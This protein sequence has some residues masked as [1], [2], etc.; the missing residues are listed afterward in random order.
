MRREFAA[1][2]CTVSIMTFATA[3]LVA[4]PGAR[5][6]ATGGVEASPGAE[7]AAPALNR[8]AEDDSTDAGSSV[9]IVVTAQRR[10]ERLVDVPI[11]ITALSGERLEQAG[12]TTPQQLSQVTPGFFY[13]M[14]AVNSQPTVRGV[15]SSNV[16]PG[17]SANVATYIDGVYQPSQFGNIF[18][19]NDIE[20]IEVLKGPQGTLFGRNAT[21]GAVLIH[22]RKP[23]L[24]FSGQL[25][26]RYGSFNAFASKLYVTG[27][28]EA[29]AGSISAIYSR[30]DGYI[31]NIYLDKQVG[32]SQ[33]RAVKAKLLFKPGENTQIL[34]GG[35]YS[36]VIDNRVL[37]PYFVRN[38]SRVAALFPNLPVA[39]RPYTTAIGLIPLAQAKTYDFNLSLQHDFGSVRLK[40]ISSYQRL[41]FRSLTD[42]D[43][44]PADL[45]NSQ[46]SVR[47]RSYAEELTLSSTGSNRLDWTAGL[48]LF[49]DNAGDPAL[50]S[51]GVVLV[52]SF[53][54]TKAIGIF[55]ELDWELADRLNLI[56]GGRYSTEKRTLT[57]QGINPAS[58]VFVNSERWN[59]FTP[60]VSIRYEVTD[61]TNV[62]GTFSK[63]FKSGAFNAS[64]VPPT[65]QTVIPVNP[66]KI[67][68]YEVGAKTAAGRALF[69][70]AAYYYDYKDIQV[71]AF[72]GNTIFTQ[73]QNAA[74]AK[75]WG[76]EG[77]ASFEPLNDLRINAGASYVHARY[78][79]FP[80][81][82]VLVPAAAGGNTQVRRDVSH[83]RMIR[84]PDYTLNL[85]ATYSTDTNLGL[86]ELSVNSQFSGKFFWDVGNTLKE[87]PYNVTN[88]RLSLITQGDRFRISVFADNIFDK[89][90]NMLAILNGFGTRLVAARP[91]S[92]GAEAEVRF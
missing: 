55:G 33:T 46:Q 48:F 63:G 76:L 83:N 16:N 3:S 52:N 15:G 5:A 45:A 80:N 64:A 50:R 1:L 13:S 59:S 22:T 18:E 60:R 90:Y 23:E 88:A 14:T 30:D 71:A 38:S 85:G 9:D 92:V 66:E 35:G 62:Y 26:A 12:I 17:D 74:S 41:R 72:V 21:G 43:A 2:R 58:P 67:T 57:A 24:G 8:S 44:G 79:S 69:S 53:T 10:E 87:K 68:A 6:Q 84:Q 78:D 29:V 34:I 82:V 28:S 81:A 27:G 7:T 86:F 56:V 75:I 37:N 61:R 91:A 65:A 40:S 49:D 31:R 32:N 54:R 51:N 47:Q 36:D 89:E 20:R 19:F 11:S 77:E 4:V 70:A 73:L 25:S 39:N 42:I